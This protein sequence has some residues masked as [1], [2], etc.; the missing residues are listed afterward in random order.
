MTGGVWIRDGVGSFSNRVTRMK[1]I[2]VLVNQVVRRL[3]LQDLVSRLPFYLLCCL[4]LATVAIALPK[5]LYW[6]PLSNWAGGSVWYLAWAWGGVGAALVLCFASC[7]RTRAS[8]LR[9]A[10]ELDRRCGL[11]QRVSSTLATSAAASDPDFYH[12]LLADTQQ[13]I[14]DLQVGE[15]FPIAPR[16]HLGLPLLPI[17]LLLGL[18]YLPNVR[19]PM[20]DDESELTAETREELSKLIQAANVKKEESSVEPEEDLEGAEMVKKAMEVAEQTLAKKDASKR[21]ILVAINDVKKA[22]QDQQDRLGKT[23]AL[24]ERLNRLKEQTQGPAEKFTKALKDG[25]LKEAQE[26]MAQLAEKLAKGE[27]SKDDQERLGKQMEELKN[28][29]DDIKD[30]FEKQKQDLQRQIERAISEGD[31]QRAADLEKQKAGLEQQQKQMDQL[32][33]MA[34]QAGKI[35]ELLK[36]V[37]DGKELSEAQQQQLSEAMQQMEAQMQE[38]QL[39]EQ[40]MRELQKMMDQM[41]EMK[42]KMR[43][44]GE[45]EGGEC[46][47]DGDG[48]GDGDKQKPGQGMGAGQGEGLRPEAEDETKFYDTQTK[49]EVRPGEVAKIGQMGGANRKGV[50]QVEIQNAIQEAAESKELTPNDLQDIPFNQR[51]HVRQYFQKLR[52]N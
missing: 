6:S 37:Q 49:P 42:Q 7:W 5:C 36:D 10:E 52:G 32:G 12:A 15:Q 20:A 45:C 1:Q 11:Q 14:R 28:Q 18:G 39:N 34:E 40:Q 50:T 2:E 9:A 22:V 25:N 3:F 33:K 21:E 43:G 35:A 4:G 13:R 44:E 30:A 31:L 41:E 48:D 23:D 17:L 16:W 46:E 8:R 26:Q 51:E 47:G 29:V 38:M 24:K 19:S 27:M